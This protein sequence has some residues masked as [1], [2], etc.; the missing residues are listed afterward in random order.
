LLLDT[1]KPPRLALP[2]RFSLD[3]GATLGVERLPLPEPGV[4]L[5]EERAFLTLLAEHLGTPRAG[6]AFG[7]AQK[8]AG[9]LLGVGPARFSLSLWAPG[10]RS[11]RRDD[12]NAY[13]ALAPGFDL[14]PLRLSPTAVAANARPA[15]GVSARARLR[16]QGG[17]FS[18]SLAPWFLGLLHPDAP[19]FAGVGGRLAASVAGVRLAYAR[20]HRLAAP[21]TFW[22]A[23]QVA[24]REDASLAYGPLALAWT[25]DLAAGW[26]R[27]GVG[28][29]GALSLEVKKGFGSAANRLELVAGYR[30]GDPAPGG[31]ALAPSLGYDFGLG[32]VSRF[33]L[34]LAYADG[35]FVYRLRAAAALA[36]WPGETA[37]ARFSLG[38]SLR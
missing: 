33:A 4:P 31:F 10:V 12:G 19:A 24:E 37:G 5:G 22:E 3:Q 7:L 38:L 16:W 21:A 6:L 8:D 26:A 27:A 28:Y 9:F 35:C 23:E 11:E 1:R 17:G 18:L 14:G 36:P 20:S 25:R 32:R 2:L 30:A 34:D 15:Y 29:R 13:L